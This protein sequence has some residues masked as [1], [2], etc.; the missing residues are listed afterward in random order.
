MSIRRRLRKAAAWGFL[1]VLAVTLGG[2]IAAYFYATDSETLS[3]LVRREAPRFLPGCR[4]DVA[5]VRVRPFLG[6]ILVTNLLVSES[7]ETVGQAARILVKYDPW[8][9]TKGRFE[10]REVV[11]NKPLLRLRRRLDGSWNLQGLLADPWPVPMGGGTSPPIA[12][13]QGTL[14]LSEDGDRPPLALLHD[15]AITIPAGAGSGAPVSFDLTAKGDVFDRLHV[16]GTVDPKTGRVELKAGELVRLNLSESLRDRLPAQVRDALKLAGLAGGEVDA[17]LSSLSFDPLAR[18]ALH[19]SVSAQLRRGLWQCRKLPFPISEVSVDA[20]ARDGELIISRASGTDGKTSFGLVGRATIGDP[21]RAPFACRLE[22]TNLELDGRLRRFTPKKFQE[23]WDLYFPEVGLSPTASAG[24]LNAVVNLARP[25]PGA[26]VDAVVDVTDLDVSVEYRHFAYKVDHVHGK[27]HATPKKMTLALNAMVGNGALV[28][29]GDVDNPGPDAVARLDFL[30]ESLPVDETLFR[31]LPPDVRQVVNDFKPSG[32]VQGR[33]KLFREPPLNP[34]ED[35]RGRVK[36]D[37]VVNLIPGRCSITWKELKYPVRNLTGTLEIHPNLWTFSRM[38]GNNGQ[39]VITADGRVEQVRR[40]QFKV[41]LKLKAENLPFDQQLRDALPRPWQ[42]TWETL[43]PTGASNIEADIDVVPGRLPRAE[44]DRIEIRPLGQT[45]VKLQIRRE[46]R[47]GIDPGGHLILQMDDVTGQ[48]IYDTANSPP[49]E[50]NE[51][52]F[53]FAGSPVTF[54]HGRVDVKDSG[55]F[56]LGARQLEV[57]NLRLDELLRRKMP[58]EMAH[59]ARRLDNIPIAKIRT[60]LGLGWS[61]KPGESPWCQWRDALVILDNNKVEIGA[62]LGLDHIQGQLEKVSGAFNGQALEVHGKLNL[63][64]VSILGQQV[65]GLTA[66]V[67]LKDGLASLDKIEGTVLG[68]SLNG[69]L[70]ASLDATPKYSLALSVEEAD[71]HEYA[72]VLKGHQTF[73]GLVTAWVDISGQGDDPH[74]ITGLGAARV[75][76]G[77]LG[78]LPVALRFMNALKLAKETRTAFDSADLAFRIKYGQTTLD[79][80]HFFGNAFSLDGRGTLDVGGELDLKLRILA[81][82]DTW[83]LPVL[84]DFTRELSGQILV[85]RV[86]GPVGAPTFKPEAIPLTGELFRRKAGRPAWRTGLEPRLRS[87]TLLR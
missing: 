25:S 40:N 38:H 36:F 44:H 65:T 20:R 66:D 54:K 80:V 35:P 12:I 61:G 4:V 2:A 46:P 23:I 67:D 50:M 78:R 39:A 83:H 22:A 52:G 6:E 76:Q 5:K 51:V 82:R 43:N 10:P 1:L 33:A 58:P 49:T 59:A 21:S 70:R 16:E 68:G 75:V 34:G 71:L 37:A 29:E 15:V 60:D 19:Y 79:P 14:E 73:K 18:P 30:V 42:V 26:E 7:D 8:A 48:F 86:H 63:D 74:T 13:Q 87:G 81:G 3:E 31:A 57:S 45:G 72:Q 62:D 53:N 32:T 69:S 24:R 17:G 77:D 11:V 55:E 9:M 41:D 56:S 64:S 47:P 85:V 84:S 28:V 27:I